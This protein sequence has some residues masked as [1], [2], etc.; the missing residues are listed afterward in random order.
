[1]AQL[2]GLSADVDVS[3]PVSASP[4]SERSVYAPLSAFNISAQTTTPTHAQ[5]EFS[6]TAT[7]TPTKPTTTPT[8]SSSATSQTSDGWEEEEMDQGHK[9]TPG[10]IQVSVTP[11]EPVVLGS[12]APV[13]VS[14]G[15]KV[16]DLTKRLPV[17]IC[18][19]IDISGS[20][21]ETAKYQDEHDNSV[22]HD[23]G[24]TILDLVKHSVKTVMHMLTPEDRVA[25]VAFDDY[26]TTH[27]PLSEMTPSGM[28]TA[29]QALN[30]MQPAG[31]TNIW[32]GLLA[33]LEALRDTSKTGPRKKFVLLLTDGLPT[34]VPP[35]GHTAELRK[36]VEKYPG[37]TF[38]INTFGFGY[39]VDSDLLTELATMAGGTFA[40]IPDAKIVGTCFVD[41]VSNA[42]SGMVQTSTLHLIP[43]NG[44]RFAGDVLGGLPTSNTEWG[45][46]VSLGPLQCGQMRDIVVPMHMTFSSEEYL[47]VVL[48]YT[49]PE[50][51]EIRE[52]ISGNA[53][54]PS[55]DSMAALVRCN[56]VDCLNQVVKL[57]SNRQGMTANRQLAE[58]KTKIAQIETS[59]GADCD[60]RIRTLSA[61]VQGRVTKALSTKERFM[62]WGRHYVRA[63]VRAHQIQICT[64]FMDSSLQVYCG[65]LFVEE[66]SRGGKIFKN[67]EK[68][69]RIPPEPKPAPTVAPTKP[70]TPQTPSP[71]I[72]QWQLRQIQQLQQLQ[73]EEE[74]RIQAQRA[75]QAPP[76]SFRTPSPPPIYRE[77]SPPPDNSMDNYYAGSSGGC[78]APGCRVNIAASPESSF[79]TTT[80]DTLKR[81]DKVLVAGGIASVMCVIKISSHSK[82]LYELPSGLQITGKHPI[83]VKGM[84]H[85]ARD[86]TGAKEVAN[87]S[88]IVYN[89]VLDSSHVLLVNGMECATWGHGMQGKSPAEK[90]CIE[91]YFYGTDKI[92]AALTFMDGWSS[93]FI[94]V[95]GSIRNKQ[96]VL[97]GFTQ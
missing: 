67:L 5:E 73:F 42:V 66:R 24:I 55:M 86:I 92:I 59:Q 6:S 41:S 7:A 43:Q 10:L 94:T 34:I 39:G 4:T 77:P 75:A 91:H 96:G 84:W 23:D 13:N 71:Q 82:P 11:C 80:I 53:K 54:T 81:G 56:V 89:L 50:G 8:A 87:P 62:R 33:G 68:P 12:T 15:I 46:M 22:L 72:Q 74:Q 31:S 93:G 37:F 29:N 69:K 51:S 36:Y 78:F 20:M 88:G 18:C 14:I 85:P 45:R 44:A 19:V 52:V 48:V 28:N 1:M 3:T 40:F 64:N 38:Q 83:R 49:S 95:T 35:H 9:F 26:A 79:S 30:R 61:D 2:L 76:P 16:P 60:I 90:K 70:S 65:K 58:M 47:E 25:L 97:V 57:A 17:D 21:A 27:F 63:L 32:S